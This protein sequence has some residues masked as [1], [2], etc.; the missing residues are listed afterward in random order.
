MSPRHILIT[1]CNRGIGLELVKQYLKCSDPPAHLFATCRNPD[2]ATELSGLADKNSNLHVLKLDVSDHSAYDGIKSK[3]TEVIG[4]HAGLNLLINN[5]GVLPRERDTPEGVTPEKMRQAFEVN[6]VSPLF[7]SK[8]LLPLVKKAA[9][10]NPEKSVSVDKAAIVMMSTAVASVAENSGGGNYAYRCSKSALNMAMKNLSIDLKS[11]GV[12]VMSMHP[13]WVKTEMGGPNALID[14]ETCCSTMLE[15]L[16]GLN[17][18]DHGGFK[19]Y[20]NTVIPW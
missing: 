18:S 12:L 9:E 19:R 5:A 8:A 13:G 10:K 6:C 20:N 14:T 7:F 11:D 16:Q 1:G 15:T 4:E 17:E 3:I 2:Q